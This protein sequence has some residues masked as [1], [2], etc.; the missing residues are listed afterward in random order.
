MEKKRKGR[1]EMHYKF[2]ARGDW[3]R[4]RCVFCGAMVCRTRYRVVRKRGLKFYVCLKCAK[5]KTIYGKPF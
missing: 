5:K 2:K 3:G 1:T 4:K